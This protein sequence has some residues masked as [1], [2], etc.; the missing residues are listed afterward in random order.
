MKD[1][2]ISGI[3]MSVMSPSIQAAAGARAPRSPL[4]G[5]RH[6]ATAFR[7][8]VDAWPEQVYEEGLVQGRLL[9][10]PVTYVVDPERIRTL[11]VDDAHRLVRDDAMTRALSPALGQGLLTSA[12]PAWRAQ[13]RTAAPAFRPDRV[14][15]LAP[16]MARVASAT[17]AR[18]GAAGL[19]RV[20]DLQSE[21]MRTTLDVIVAAMVSDDEGFDAPAFSRALDAYL[22]QTNW[23]IA[24]GVMG[25]P[26]WVPHPRCVTG[27]M[28]ARQL[29]S[30]TSLVI[31]A[32]RRRG[33]SGGDLLGAM[34]ASAGP[35]PG[36]GFE[37]DRVVDN[38]L[39]FVM[40]GHETTALALTWTLRLIADH[41]D[42]ERRM[43]REIEGM[44]APPGEPGAVDQLAYTRQV[45]LEAMRLY[46]PAALLVRRAAEDLRVGDLRVPAG[47]SIHIPVY[48]LHRHRR[49][50]TDPDAFDPDRFEP[51]RSKDR[52][53]FAFI[54]FGGGPRVCI[55]M[56]MAITECL[57]ILATL[58]PRVRLRPTVPSL[59][60]TR[61]RVT[62]RPV[63][64]VP[65]VVEPREGL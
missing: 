18:W 28:A 7:N 8:L 22:G 39:T 9:G 35:E 29:R 16:A 59:P 10:R 27:A 49:L 45:V 63:G 44:A 1:I 56:G 23:S 58:L 25:V 57:V 55:G 34:L 2:G 62:L 11:L 54:P 5:L 12:G 60:G 31:A 19:P 43:L 6:V 38:L 50:W 53:R 26:A 52:H 14:S 64:G 40:A 24:F 32:R 41:P 47:G 21:M 37:A 51:G 48:A 33:E 46:P 15:A 3:A 30:M 20:V 4:A 17:L 42:V 13:R 65:M 36:D 61:L